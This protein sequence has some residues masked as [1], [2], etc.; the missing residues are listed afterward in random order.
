MLPAMRTFPSLVL[1]SAGLLALGCEQQPKP[2]PETKKTT[3]PM[4]APPPVGSALNTALREKPASVASAMATAV[5]VAPKPAGLPAPEDVAAPPKTAKKT[6]SGVAYV[7]LEK[8]KGTKKPT[9]EDRVKVHYSGWT[10]DGKMFDSSVARNEPATFGVGQVIPG[11]TEALK[12][13]VE[14]QKLRVWIPSNLAYGDKPGMGPTGQLT[15]EIE[16]LEIVK[17]PKPPKAPAD[18][19]AAPKSAKKT[20]SGLAYRSLKKGKGA[21]HPTR[22][23]RVSVHYTGWTT[24]GK[25]FDSSIPRGEPTTFPLGQVIKGW[26]E[27]L[28][29]MV[30]G[31]TMRFWI[32]AELAY[33]EKPTRP[34]APAG[35]LVFDVELIAIQSGM[36]SGHAGH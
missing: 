4:E 17:T 8:G 1:L 34:G 5:G 16:L 35:M 32:P 29:L 7:V 10:A 26:G 25:M 21:K 2:E 6:A 15:F 14:G 33:G 24:D 22:A 28:Q 13:M 36:P 3:R 11:W 20:E 19:R 12:L 9:Q 27:G 23:D 30:E 31:E 18:V